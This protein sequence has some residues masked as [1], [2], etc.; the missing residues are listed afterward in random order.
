MIKKVDNNYRV[1]IPIE[2]R[3][4]VG[5]SKGQ[6]LNLNLVDGNIVISK[7]NKN[8]KIESNTSK[9]KKSTIKNLKKKISKPV[10]KT[11]SR[12][13]DITLLDMDL[14]KVKQLLKTPEGLCFKCRRQLNS[15]KFKINGNYV[16]KTCRDKL[17]DSII[18]EMAYEKRRQER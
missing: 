6:Y 14:P 15:S 13:S 4:K 16:C 10:K 12:L 3:E 2:L 11:V 17:R 5:I 1:L 18:K 9:N 8:Q 7:L